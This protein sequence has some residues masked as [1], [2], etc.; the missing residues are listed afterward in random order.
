MHDRR[1]SLLTLLVAVAAFAL[2]ASAHAAVSLQK[3]GDFDTPI[4][5]TAAPGDSSRLYVVERAGVVRV[6]HDGATE[7]DPF[8]TLS[9]VDTTGERG[10]LSIAFPPN[11][12][13]TH[14]FYAYFNNVSDGSIEVDELRAS[15]ADHADPSYRHQII[16]IP[17]PGADNHNGG[18]AMFGR[19]GHLYLAPGDGGTGGAN[20]RDKDSLLGKVL[21]I[22]PTPGGG[23]TSPADNPFFG[24]AVAGADEVWS[25]GLR[26]PFRFTIDPVNGDMM[27]ADVGQSTTEEVD[28]A[29]AAGGGGR[30][31]DYGWNV[32]EGSFLMGST[33]SPCTTGTLP[34]IDEPASQGWHSIIAGYVVRDQ[35][36]PSLQG[37]FLYGDEALGK[38]FSAKLAQPH[39]T[40]Q[41]PVIDLPALTAFGL[42]GNGCTYAVS[43]NGPVYRLV[44][45]AATPCS[46]TAAAPPPTKK[47]PVLFTKT[48]RR[49]RVLHNGGVIGYGRCKNESCKVAM[50]GKL[51]IGKK[52]Y[53]LIHTERTAGAKRVK[54]RTRLTGRARSALRSALRH[55]RRATVAVAYRA[56]ALGGRRSALKHATVR[57]RR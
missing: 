32:C 12:Q 49:Q 26:N 18:T 31:V 43:L 53:S 15:D 17:H 16:N 25:Y 40:D 50:S 37:R 57:V 46:A 8:L 45:N 2:P 30:G 39:A 22:D 29:Q 35:S 21:R 56:R 44:E 19:D 42:D 23:H 24:P 6:V 5:V 41:Q 11:F 38:I 13:T 14:L 52:S 7:T 20:S 36:L 10:L 54:L 4:F 28:W 3:I 47:G 34:V 9:G 51:R 33:T 48:T 1:A 55:H 27:I